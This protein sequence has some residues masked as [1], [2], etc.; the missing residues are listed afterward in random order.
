MAAATLPLAFAPLLGAVA[1]AP[2]GLAVVAAILDALLAVRHGTGLRVRLP[3]VVRLARERPGK[4]EVVIERTG[5]SVG[6][7][8][9]GAPFPPEIKAEPD[10]PE[11]AL[12]PGEPTMRHAWPVVARRR[13]RFRLDAMHWEIASPM[14]LWSRREKAASSCEIRVHPDLRPDRRL[15]AAYFLPRGAPGVRRRR[16]VGRGRE[17]EKLRDYLPGDPLGDI[18]WKATARRR[19]LVTREFQVERTQEVYVILDCSR[20]SARPAPHTAGLAALH[21]AKVRR[22]AALE[23]ADPFALGPEPPTL[24]ERNLSAAFLLAEAAGKQGDLFGFCAF[25]DQVHV[26]LRARSGPAHAQ[27]CREA[28]HAL[29]PR[30]VNPDFAEVCAQLRGALRRRALLIFLTALD[31]PALAEEFG[32]HAPLLSRQHLVLAPMVRPPDALP[33]FG[34]NPALAPVAD[35]AALYER[36]SGHLRWRELQETGERLRHAGVR[37]SL[38]DQERLAPQ[39]IQ[40]YLDVKARQIL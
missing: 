28:L 26:F 14:G 29:E 38:L 15:A 34:E 11:I 25:S 4:L 40:T 18:Q 9:I 7:V 31:D 22:H 13:G 6:T 36:V 2:L 35:S 8:R 30:L 10:S 21:G 17:F 39:L 37:F 3:E 23:D 20:L 19:K 24:L 33:L 16:M 5:G 12:P 27:A 32:R 1:W